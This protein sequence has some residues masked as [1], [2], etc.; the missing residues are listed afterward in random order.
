M[1]QNADR[2]GEQ[3]EA[4]AAAPLTEVLPGDDDETAEKPATPILGRLI[5]GVLLVNLFAGL[6]VGL[7][8]HQ[9][10]LHYEQTATTASRNLAQTTEQYVADLIE[11][12]DYLLFDTVAEVEE[13]L[14]NGQLDQAKVN[15]FINERQSLLVPLEAIRIADDSGQ[16]IFGSAPST[17][18]PRNLSD[19][20]YFMQQR[21]DPKGGLFISRSHVSRVT[22]RWSI[23]FSRRISRPD[24]SFYGIAYSVIPADTVQAFF[25]L[26]DVGP[27]GG[28]SL[29]DDK[30]TTLVRHPDPEGAH[31]G[32]TALSPEL[33]SFLADGLTAAAFFSPTA[34][35]TAP[36]M[37]AVRKIGRFPLFIKIALAE[38][39]Y[40]TAWRAEMRWFSA[41]YAV[42]VVATLIWAFL[43]YRAWLQRVQADLNARHTLEQRV[44]EKTAHLREYATALERSNA[45][46]EQFAYVASHDLREPLRMVSSYLGLLERRYGQSFDQDGHE[47]IAYAKEGAVRMDRLVQ[48]LLNF[49]RIGRHGNPP[50][51]TAIGPLLNEVVRVLNRT[52]ADAGAQV[53]LPANPPELICCGDE[54]FL[55]FQNLLGN[56]LKFRTPDRPPVIRVDAERQPGLWHFSVSDNGIGI[57]PEYFGR[58]FMIF[59]RLHTR[60]RYEGTGIGLAVCKKIVERHGGSIW[61]ESVPG[62]GST[63]HFTI[64]DGGLQ[65]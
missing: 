32:A 4:N 6:L 48:D 65:G 31:R 61:V 10:L 33:E 42:F 5:L 58:I 13:Q 12:I 51:P 34:T 57:D 64:P 46:L 39:D 28:L 8:M 59:Q 24:G 62:E 29:R 11:K 45:D 50:A 21:D 18:V 22:G 19:R 35:E 54:L 26:I 53:E 16:V 3:P 7:S 2:S 43:L 52:I 36:G 17:S 63:F 37:V 40:L 47:F 20:D 55:L 27:H 60:D 9:S 44:A 25:S 1:K 23:F 38:Q 41:L 49:S 30:L 14:R 56:A 15:T